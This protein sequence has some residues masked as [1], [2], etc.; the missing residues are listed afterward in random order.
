MCIRDSSRTA[1]RQGWKAAARCTICHCAISPT[2][3]A[4]AARRLPP[5]PPCPHT[6]AADHRGWNCRP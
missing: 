2:P 3:R 5:R 6:R 4:P 1:S